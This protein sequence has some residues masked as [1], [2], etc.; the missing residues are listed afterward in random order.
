VR[1]RTGHVIYIKNDQD[2]LR[3]G[4]RLRFTV[5]R[6]I[7]ETLRF[8]DYRGHAEV[9]VTFT[10]DEKIRA[11]NREHRGKDTSTDVLSFPMNEKRLLGDIVISL[12]HAACQADL[13]GHSFERETAFLTVHSMLHLLG[14]DHETS[15]GDER[16]MFARQEI[17]L[18]L[19]GLNK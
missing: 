6:A 14:Y 3:A 2:K 7:A 15:R 17:I 10:D 1:R 12:E 18:N 4:V 5:K 13:Y 11:L 8:E 9:S 19:M 16:D